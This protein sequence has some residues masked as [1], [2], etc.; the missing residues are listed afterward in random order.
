MK[1]RLPE[2]ISFNTSDNVEVI[3]FAYSSSVNYLLPSLN[4]FF[5]SNCEKSPSYLSSSSF[6]IVISA[7]RASDLEA[8]KNC[9]NS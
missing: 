9:A 6:M 7:K 4:E 8:V 3:T 1:F 5:L 2:S